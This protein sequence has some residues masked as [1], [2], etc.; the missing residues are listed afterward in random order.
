MN[1]F[2]AVYREVLTQNIQRDLGRCILCIPWRHGNI[3]QMI[4]V[5]IK[6][7]KITLLLKKQ[8][9]LLHYIMTCQLRII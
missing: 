2:V 6:A 7:L 8:Y 5:N 1:E 4:M 9:T 3:D